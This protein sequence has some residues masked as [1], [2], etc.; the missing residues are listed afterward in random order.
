MCRADR[1]ALYN[2]AF[3]PK[4]ETKRRQIK[5]KKPNFRGSLQERRPAAAG[6]FP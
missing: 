6:L 3:H 5:V 4:I 2:T 1:D